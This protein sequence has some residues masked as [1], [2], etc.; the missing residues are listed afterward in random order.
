MLGRPALE[1]LENIPIEVQLVE[2]HEPTTRGDRLTHRPS[3]VTIVAVVAQ[4][5]RRVTSR[6]VQ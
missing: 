2:H 3:I 1:E 6:Y 5:R 4:N